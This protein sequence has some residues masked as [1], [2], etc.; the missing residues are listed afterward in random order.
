M[1]ESPVLATARLVL[2]PWR[3]SDALAV[4]GYANDEAWSRYLPVPRPYASADAE[5]FV[6]TAVLADRALHPMFTVTLD[7][8]AIGGIDLHVTGGDAVASLGYSLAA[9]YWGQGYTLEAATAVI[10]WAFPALGLA[11]VFATADERNRQ[12]WRV[13]EKLGMTRE[14]VLRSHRILRGERQDVVY[15]GLLREEWERAAGGRARG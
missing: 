14:G 6:A 12:S 15:Y 1:V 13:M 4:A 10:D 2:R 11:K 8:I 5:W 7:G 3:L 9:M